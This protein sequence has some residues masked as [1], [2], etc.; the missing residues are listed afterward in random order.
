MIYPCPSFLIK[1]NNGNRAIP[2]LIVVPAHR[3]THTNK[4]ELSDKK[5]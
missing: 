5:N 1:H 2:L 3:H 4:A